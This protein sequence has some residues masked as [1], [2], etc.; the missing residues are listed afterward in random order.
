MLA[1]LSLIVILTVSMV[2]VRAAAV[3]L[4]HTGLPDSVARFQCLSAFTGAGFTT[5]ESEQI[6]N[7]PIRRQIL[8]W[9][10]LGGNLGMASVIATFVTSLAFSD[11]SA[12][13]VVVQ[14][15]WMLAVIAVLWILML[16]RHSDEV[17]CAVIGRILDRTTQLGKRSYVRTLQVSDGFSVIEHTYRGTVQARLGEIA[18]DQPMT[19]IAVHRADGSVDPRATTQTVVHPRDVLVVYGSDDD[20]EELED[21]MLDSSPEG[22]KPQ[23]SRQ[24]YTRQTE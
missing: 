23:R 24:P 14:I 1:A 5:T 11:G 16:N 20:H 2:V 8:S 4:R 3:A 17:L 12:Q 15:L 9:L 7:Y 6:V 10:M 19:Y 13:E 22:D 18:S 21:K